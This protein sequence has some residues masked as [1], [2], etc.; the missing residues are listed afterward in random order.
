[1]AGLGRSI[2]YLENLPEKIKLPFWMQE[3][4]RFIKQDEAIA[5]LEQFDD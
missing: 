5:V 4:I 1:M 2:G 3:S